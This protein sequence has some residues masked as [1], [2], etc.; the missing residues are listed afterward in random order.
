MTATNKSIVTG[1]VVLAIIGGL[2]AY[3]NRDKSLPQ[4]ATDQPAATGSD[5]LAP[6][7][8]PALGLHAGLTYTQ[9]VAKY[10]ST[11]IQFDD[12]HGTVNRTSLGSL[13]VKKGSPFMLDNRDPDAH[14]FAFGTQSYRI[15][16]Q[17]FAIVSATKVG[18]FNL[19]C[20]GGGSAKLTV[21]Q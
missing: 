13:V 18:Q 4:A 14:V 11:R 3:V 15:G 16:G 2:I 8:T 10:A 9:A 17:D 12:C 6:T 7:S 21:E 20:D 1:V 5:Q 19:T